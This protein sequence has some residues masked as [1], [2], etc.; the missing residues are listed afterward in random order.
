VLA[1]WRPHA[2]PEVQLIGLRLGFCRTELAVGA[3]AEWIAARL[4]RAC[5]E[6]GTAVRRLEEG[7]FALTPLGPLR[8]LA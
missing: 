1:R 3:D 8:G 2:E 7:R 5:G 4:E 6:L